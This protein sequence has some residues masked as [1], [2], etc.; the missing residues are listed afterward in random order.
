[1]RIVKL[2]QVIFGWINYFKIANMK[3]AL[4]E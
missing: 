2:K 1:M 3:K 4:G